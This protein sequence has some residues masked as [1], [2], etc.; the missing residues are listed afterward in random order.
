MEFLYSRA[1]TTSKKSACILNSRCSLPLVDR[2]FPT[3]RKSWVL[4]R[5]ICFH[6]ADPLN[7]QVFSVG[8]QTHWQKQQAQNV[9]C[10]QNNVL[11][12]GPHPKGFGIKFPICPVCQGMELGTCHTVCGYLQSIMGAILGICINPPW[13]GSFHK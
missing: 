1:P 12:H 5:W 9:L 8:D 6:L 3:F 4:W 13:V 11:G 10:C 7:F 2:S